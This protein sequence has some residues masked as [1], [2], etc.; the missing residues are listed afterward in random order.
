VT[1][2]AIEHQGHARTCPACGHL[3]RTA[4][5]RAIRAHGTGP[6]LAAA[7]T[8]FSGVLHLSKRQVE[9][10][11]EDIFAAPLALGTVTALEREA[12]AAL[13][14]AYQEATAA[15]RAAPVQNVAETSWK[16]AG[17]LCWLWTV[18]TRGVTLFVIHS[19]RG[20]DGLRALLGVDLTA[21]VGS[22]RWVVYD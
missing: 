5:P 18:V 12:A 3:N 8:Y 16:R 9:E 11:V 17:K 21:I 19:K 10:A 1:A 22:D 6:N 4:I 2:F 20:Y 13:E 15:A 7:V 14:P